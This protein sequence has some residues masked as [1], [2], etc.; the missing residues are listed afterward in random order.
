MESGAGAEFARSLSRGMLITG[1]VVAPAGLVV[2]SLVGGRGVVAGAAVGFAVAALHSVLMVRVLLWVLKKPPRLL[3]SLLMA[4][5]FLRIAALA[6]VLYGLYFVKALN[7]LSLLVAFLAMY[8]T[9]AS[10]EIAYALKYY[11]AV[12]RSGGSDGGEDQ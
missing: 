8:T 6:A 1:A 7:M 5:Y 2:A 12:L 9:H 11:G 10:M 3:P 4:S